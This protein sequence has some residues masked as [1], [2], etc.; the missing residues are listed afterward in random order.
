MT[1]INKNFTKYF[2]KSC[3]FTKDVVY[4]NRIGGFIM[5]FNERQITK[6]RCFCGVFVFSVRMFLC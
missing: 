4:F 2:E 3:I 5:P 6:N 1:E